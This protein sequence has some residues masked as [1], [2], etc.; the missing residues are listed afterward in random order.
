MH[1][2]HSHALLRVRG[3]GSKT[4]ALR[5]GGAHGRLDDGVGTRGAVAQKYQKRRRRAE[6]PPGDAVMA[7]PAP[8]FVLHFRDQLADLAVPF[9]TLVAAR[10]GA[11]YLAVMA[12]A[13]GSGV[14]GPH[15][16]AYPVYTAAR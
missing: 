3:E 1:R 6:R 11:D 2:A 8:V 16:L 15:G 10:L 13:D 4:A 5:D 9:L 7:R 14:P 12:R